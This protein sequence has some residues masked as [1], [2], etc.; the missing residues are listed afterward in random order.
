MMRQINLFSILMIL[1]PAWCSSFGHAMSPD[2][3]ALWRLEERR[4]EYITARDVE[5]VRAIPGKSSEGWLHP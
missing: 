3:E 1:F 5:N 2:E 4:V